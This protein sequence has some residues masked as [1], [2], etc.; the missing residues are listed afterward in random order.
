MGI[1]ILYI[2]PT[3]SWGQYNNAFLLW[4][5]RLSDFLHKNKE[6]LN[7][8]IEEEYIDLRHENLPEY[9]PENLV[10]YRRSLKNLFEKLFTRFAFDIVAI[11]CYSSFCYL[12]SVEIAY[13][14]KTQINP[15]CTLIVGGPH[16]SIKPEDFQSEYIPNHFQKLYPC[17]STPFDYII[18]GEGE[19]PFFKLVHT[20]ITNGVVKRKKLSDKSVILP[21]DFILHLDELPVINLELFKKYE[22]R[23]N[24]DSSNINLDF[25]RGCM[26]RCNFC[27]NSTNYLNCYKKVRLK[28]VDKCLDELRAIRDTK[29][30]KIKHVFISDPIF[31]PKR[32]AREDFFQKMENLIKEE[33]DLG[34]QIEVEDR[35]DICSKKDL[36]NYQRVGVLP[37]FG[38]ETPSKILLY[39]LNKVLGKNASE[40][41]SGIDRYLK[42]TEEIIKFSN[43]IDFPISFFYIIGF[44]GTKKRT[45]KQSKK[46]F[47]KENRNGRSL[48][49]QYK[50]N[51][52]YGIYKALPG[53]YFYDHTDN[54][55]LKIFYKEWWK[56]F[57]KDQFLLSQI[58]RPTK[59]LAFNKMLNLYQEYL[60]D[61]FRS[62]I[63]LGNKYYSPYRYFKFRDELQNL[64][65]LYNGKKKI[66]EI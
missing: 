36:K 31:L 61:I 53:S 30:L 8:K 37:Q 59:R 50:I 12:N 5:I 26:F 34:F 15:N 56:V 42:K 51:I 9:T 52:R 14:I 16:P 40:T 65:D 11:S 60:K 38:L 39:R 10:I 48:I 2:F 6:I 55:G 64:I 21:S 33:G 19:L 63:E 47:L 58:V 23:I 20:L 24:L 22:N 32:S 54:I 4:V 25:S 57:S 1:N 35:V 62:Q 46:F 18:K 27:P 28:S 43:E 13:L 44:P 66:H 17:N 49:E 29:W 41:K 3:D 45:I 7:C